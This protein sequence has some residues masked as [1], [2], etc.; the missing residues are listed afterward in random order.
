MLSKKLESIQRVTFTR[1]PFLIK[2]GVLV[3]MYFLIGSRLHKRV[4]P[5]KV[6]FV[7]LRAVVLGATFLN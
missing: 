4:V 5:R 2:M 1:K 7:L 6:G 3:E